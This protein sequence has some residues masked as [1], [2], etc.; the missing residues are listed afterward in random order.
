MNKTSNVKFA[1]DY[2]EMISCNWIAYSCTCKDDLPDLLS[3]V[4]HQSSSFFWRPQ[5]QNKRKWESEENLLL[6]RAERT[7]D[8][9][10]SV[11]FLG[12]K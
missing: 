10:R 11:F 7:W 8:R 12:S 5:G 1:L 9:R 3:G 6:W 4:D 2:F